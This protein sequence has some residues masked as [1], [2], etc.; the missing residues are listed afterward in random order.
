[1]RRQNITRTFWFVVFFSIGAAALSGSVLCDEML[2]YYKNKQ[3]LTDAEDSLNR[4]K[5]LNT[6]Y[7]ALLRQLKEDPNFVKRIAP[8]ALGTEPSEEET[9]YP[10]VTPEQLAAARKA[11]AKDVNSQG[12]EPTLPG[13]LIRCNNS[14]HRVALFLSGGFL[15][16]I[17]FVWFG[18]A[19]KTGQNKS[20]S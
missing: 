8:A 2:Q 16:I 20:P 3:L 14:R 9:V 7:E 19:R 4:L 13:W 15:I 10:K 17:S 12:A 5:S 6:D 11:L 18:P 1:M